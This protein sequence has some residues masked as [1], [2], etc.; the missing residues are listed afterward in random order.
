[1]SG[2]PLP[3][4]ESVVLTSDEVNY[5]IY[6]YL[7]EG[8]EFFCFFVSTGGRRERGER[9]LSLRPRARASFFDRVGR[10]RAPNRVARPPR[11]ARDASRAPTEPPALQKG[12]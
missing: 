2:A 11:H 10:A 3:K 1:M 9:A 6:R 8:G 5:L 7:Q 12:R 4:A